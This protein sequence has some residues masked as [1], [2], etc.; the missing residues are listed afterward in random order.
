[1]ILPKIENIEDYRLIY[2]NAEKWFPAMREICKRHGLCESQLELAPPGAHVVFKA[3]NKYIKLFAPFWHNDSLSERLA[4]SKLARYSELP[5]SHKIVDGEIEGWQYIIMEAVEGI[6]LNKVREQ[7]DLSDMERIVSACGEFMAELHSVDTEGLDEIAVNWHGFVK[8]Q[9][10]NCI[11]NVVDNGLDKNWV[12]SLYEFAERSSYFFEMNSKPVLLNADITDE[13]VMVRK[14]NGKWDFSG[15]IDFG[16]AMLGHRLYEFAAPGCKITYCSN[17]L[18]IAM[19][20][21]Y[22]F[23]EEQLD[24]KLSEQLMAY[25]IIHRYIKISELLELFKL[26]H[27]IDIKDLTKRLWSF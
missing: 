19:L 17:K 10:Q 13:H 3:N 16:D 27:L 22:G 25:T 23:S 14:I 6:P 15:I 20:K 8:N 1:M 26:S 12:Q 9:I 24:E 5:I 4:L 18:R 2:R 11:K 7:L 21:S